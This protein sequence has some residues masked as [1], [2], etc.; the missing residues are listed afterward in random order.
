MKHCLI[1][2]ESSDWYIIPVTKLNHWWDEGSVADDA[3]DYA[4]YV[5]ASEDV[6][7]DEYEVIA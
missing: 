4:E 7:F 6:T 3:P 5:N 1:Q 2:N